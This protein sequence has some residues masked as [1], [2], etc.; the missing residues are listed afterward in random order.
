MP[1][2]EFIGKE[3]HLA[4]NDVFINNN[5]YLYRY[6]K[7]HYVKDFEQAFKKVD[8]LITPVTP[9]LP[10]KLGEK[11]DVKDAYAMDAFTTPSNLAGICSASVP[12]GKIDNIPIGMQIMAPAFREDLM[13]NT[14]KVW[15]DIS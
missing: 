12:V 2:Y 14:M 6:G 10:H 9:I 1:G 13:F 5:G 15:Q 8:I 7:G 3:E 4:V 11:V